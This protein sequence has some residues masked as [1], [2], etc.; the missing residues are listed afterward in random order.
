MFQY[1][2]VDSPDFLIK[3]NI[4]RIKNIFI[5]SQININQN[6]R[7][8]LWKLGFCSGL[9]NF[10][11]GNPSRALSRCLT[12]MISIILTGTLFYLF[13]RHPCHKSSIISIMSCKTVALR[14]CIMSASAI[15]LYCRRRPIMA[16]RVF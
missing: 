13:Y 15:K 10:P 11:S 2:T 1:N 16:A 12:I 4:I 5:L 9:F 7:S 6:L 14:T 8:F 3:I